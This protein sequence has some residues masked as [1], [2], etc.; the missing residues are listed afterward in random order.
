MDRKPIDF[1]AILTEGLF[2]WEKKRLLFN[3]V[4]T[5]VFFLT[6]RLTPITEQPKIILYLVVVWILLGTL[7]NAFYCVCYLPEIAFQISDLRDVWKQYRWLLFSLLTVVGSILAW[8][9]PMMWGL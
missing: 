7:A 5:A 4:L 3:S 2:Y 1:A 6:R 9:I 8:L